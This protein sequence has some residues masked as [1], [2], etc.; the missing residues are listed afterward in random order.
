MDS[1]EHRERLLLL[2]QRMLR[3][4]DD[5]EDAVQET[6]LRWQKQSDDILTPHAWFATVLTRICLDKL[7]AVKKHRNEPIANAMI[8]HEDAGALSPDKHLEVSDT[9]RG[10]ASVMMKCLSAEERRALLLRE[11]LGYSYD[12][13][14]HM[15][16][17]RQDACRQLVHRARF[18]V[19]KVCAVCSRA[20]RSDEVQAFLYAIQ[21]GDEQALL[22]LM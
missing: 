12:E 14:A 17:R 3:N 1:E 8:T 11:M 20:R 13:V 6:Y 2:A 21:R 19:Q 10:I 9:L 4:Y 5:A 16:N 15:L 22:N 7:R 18:N